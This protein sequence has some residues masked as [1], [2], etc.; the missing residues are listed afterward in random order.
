MFRINIVKHLRTLIV[1]VAFSASFALMRPA[2]ANHQWEFV[3]SSCNASSHTFTFTSHNEGG[4][5]AYVGWSIYVN[6]VFLQSF[7]PYSDGPNVPAGDY[8][9]TFNN[10]AF[11][12][13]ASIR[14]QESTSITT[15]C[16]LA[17]YEGPALPPPGQRNL[18]LMLTDHAL[19]DS[20]GGNSINKVVKACQTVFVLQTSDDGK[21]GRIFSFGN[22]NTW[23]SLNNYRDVAENYGQPGGEAVYGPCVGR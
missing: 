8:S 15:T 4:T 20:A 10:P 6:N 3:S 19:L 7:A 12:E 17:P 2:L 23:I 1:L 18:I 9:F 21:F 14:V 13:G 11:V 22:S 16:T 5:S